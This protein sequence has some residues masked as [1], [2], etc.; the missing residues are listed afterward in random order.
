LFSGIGVSVVA[1][2]EYDTQASLRRHR[3]VVARIGF[4]SVLEVGEEPYYFLHVH[5]IVLVW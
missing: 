1:E 4:V 2:F 3:R 5:T